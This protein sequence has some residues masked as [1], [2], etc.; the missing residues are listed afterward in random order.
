[1]ARVY[2]EIAFLGRNVH[3]TLEELMN[4]DHAERLRWV[5]EVSTVVDA[6]ETAV[7]T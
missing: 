7:V 3:W 2:R 5:R 6:P 4:L 1:M